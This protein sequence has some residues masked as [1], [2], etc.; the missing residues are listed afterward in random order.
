MAHLSNS[1]LA[2]S[3]LRIGYGKAITIPPRPIYPPP[4]EA[5]QARQRLAGVTGEQG[6]DPRGEHSWGRGVD[7]ETAMHKVRTLTPISTPR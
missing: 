1:L 7:A 4:A 2:G 5:Q 3:E 6:R